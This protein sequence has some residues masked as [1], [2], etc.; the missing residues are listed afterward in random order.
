MSAL[1]GRQLLSPAYAGQRIPVMEHA[2]ALSREAV[3]HLTGRDPLRERGSLNA[4]YQRAAEVLEIDLLWGGSLPKDGEEMYDWSSGPSVRHNQKGEEVV[5]WGIF[6][7]AHQEDGR[8]YTHIPK[9]ASLDAAL[10][11]QPLEYFPETTEQY[12]ARF[13]REYAGLLDGCAAVCQPIPHHYTTCFHW[14]LAIFGFELLCEAGLEDDRFHDLMQRF[15]EISCRITAAWSSVRDA[16]GRPL[17]GFICHDDLTMTS[18]PLFSPDWYRRHIF[19]HYP[20]IFAP[21]KAAGIPIIFTSDGNC[22]AFIDD[23]LDVAGAD[24]L[25]FEYSVSLERLVSDYPDKILIGNL[26]SAT[27]ARGPLAAIEAETRACLK[28]GAR[29]RRFVAN[30]GGGLTHDIPLAHLDYYLA[31]RKNLC[32]TLRGG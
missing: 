27:L 30:V 19:P 31:L 8:H 22:S 24:G 26:N 25:N 1:L 21:L 17:P 3:V 28:T 32:R 10:D 11:F 14:A 12:A 9:P 15:A 5:R 7:T 18:G 29:G 23:I 16:A 4:I 6:A 2:W 20:A 13:T